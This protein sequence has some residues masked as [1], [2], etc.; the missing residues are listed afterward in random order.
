MTVC[1]VR[2]VMQKTILLLRLW[3][4]Q[5][6]ECSPR[7]GSPKPHNLLQERQEP[8]TLLG[9]PDC[10]SLTLKVRPTMTHHASGHDHGRGPH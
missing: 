3:C 7:P 10:F 8:C 4:K 1:K 6:C 9:L 5:P 2:A